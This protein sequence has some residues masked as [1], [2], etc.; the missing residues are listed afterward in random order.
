[1]KKDSRE[2]SRRFSSGVQLPPPGEAPH[3]QPAKHAPAVPKIEPQE[4]AVVARRPHDK[5]I[6]VTPVEGFLV[7][8][9]TR[10]EVL[11]PEL[12]ARSVRECDIL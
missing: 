9:D 10:S 2:A 3:G 5:V 8:R 4:I 6:K 7:D 12:R 1:M 11:N